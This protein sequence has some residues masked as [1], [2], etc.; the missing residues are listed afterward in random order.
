MTA[1][2]S[3]RELP[4]SPFRDA[5]GPARGAGS[6]WRLYA[7]AW[8]VY[9][10]A[11]LSAAIHRGGV[12]GAIGV[13]M[14]SAFV[15]LY[16]S[17]VPRGFRN[18]RLGPYV[19]GALLALALGMLPFT[20]EQGLASFVFV[21]VAAL[22]ALPRWAGYAVL[23]ALTLLAGVLPYAIS[24]W[25][26]DGV[27][28][29]VQILLA[30]A[31]ILAMFSLLRANR[32]LRQAREDLTRLA[33]LEER[34]R[35]ARDIHDVLGHT[36][37][38]ITLKATLA[39]RLVADDAVRATAEI[40][41]VERLAREGLADVR[42]TVTATRNVSLTG[43][44]SSARAAL[45]AA[46]IEAQLPSAVDDVPGDRRELF[47]WAIREGV[48]NVLRHSRARRCVVTLT[49]TTV[50]IQDDGDGPPSTVSDG[51]NGLRGL[52]D[53]AAELGGLVEAGRVAGGYRLRVEVPAVAK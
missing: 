24:S 16:A 12:G 40:A 29:A 9:M 11:P 48:T 50:E 44:L 19:A 34:E 28:Q 52:T 51:G 46:G 42:A 15:A 30:A 6:R 14:V 2:R 37:T 18:M 26:N 36:L 22:V 33:A 7:S 32:E 1:A 39:Q 4:W 17:G 43:E 27:V 20:G 31:V 35:I 49:S 8:L 3:A 41:D 10:L 13:V 25:A 23:I 53:R 5:P 45:D 38:V 21:A 47:G